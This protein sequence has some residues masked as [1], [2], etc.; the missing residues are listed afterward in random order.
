ME[1]CL[2]TFRSVKPAQRADILLRRSGFKCSLRRTPR[3]MEERGCGY[4]IQ[5]NYTDVSN[6]VN[7]LRSQKVQFRKVYLIRENG[8]AEELGL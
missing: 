3:W 8:G 4:S 2:I 6:C 1:N 5:V 7:I